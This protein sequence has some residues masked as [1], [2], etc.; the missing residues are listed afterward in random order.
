MKALKKEQ[1]R[2]WLQHVTHRSDLTYLLTELIS[3]LS[4]GHAYVEGG[5]YLLP[6]RAKVG[7]PGARLE[8]D[9]AAGRYRI[10]KIY[11]GQNEEAKYH[12]P[13]TEMGVDA[14]EG[15]Y[16]LA[17]DGVEL[18]PTEDP[19]RLL[20]NKTFSVTLT[21]NSKAGFEGARKITYKPVESEASLRYLEFVQDAKPRWS[22]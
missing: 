3:E 5:D 8:F 19:Y 15:D 6:D 7:L 1:Y 11:G 9:E 22:A 12:S 21:V 17:I 20:R 18:K 14:R 13:L 2:P 16:V 10:A 4:I